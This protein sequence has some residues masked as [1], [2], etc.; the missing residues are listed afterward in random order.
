MVGKRC[1][2]TKKN[3]FT[4]H[5]S[6]SQHTFFFSHKKS[7]RQKNIY[8]YP[9]G[10]PDGHLTCWEKFSPPSNK[11]L[12]F[13]SGVLW[14]FFLGVHITYTHVCIIIRMWIHS[15]I[16][17]LNGRALPNPH[18]PFSLIILVMM[19][20]AIVVLERDLLKKCCL[21]KLKKMFCVYQVHTYYGAWW[22]KIGKNG[23]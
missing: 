7:H 1:T 4:Q 9:H 17:F 18:L 20:T 2:R 19:M 12:V 3:Y 11:R 22:G 6:T 21:L 5:E 10:R 15:N 13:T 23:T 16:F 8:I 14:V